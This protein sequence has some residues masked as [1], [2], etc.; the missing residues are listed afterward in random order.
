[1]NILITETL[2]PIAADWLAQRAQVVWCKHDDPGFTDALAQAEG[3]IVRTY[4][5]VND[6][7]L[8]QA[9]KLKVVGR[10][11]VGLDNINVPACRKRNIEVVYTP[12][13]NTQAVVEYV[14]G[15]MLDH[16][17]PRKDLPPSASAA[18]FHQMRKTEVGTQLDQLTLGILGFGRIGKKL[19]RVAHALGM[20]VHAC[21]LLPEAELRKAVNYPFEFVDHDKLYA[22]SDIVTIHID[23]RPRN[24]HLVNREMLAKLKPNVLLINAARG[25]IVDAAALADWARNHP[26]AHAI[27]DVHDPEPPEVKTYPLWDLPNVRLL[28]HLA[29]RTDTAL[30][31]M[32][33]VVRDVLDVLEGGTPQFPAEKLE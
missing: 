10:A 25:M 20:S 11:G 14:L 18:H 27:L 15:L 7:L 32:S 19:G 4:T 9:P 1:M 12:D 23:G 21:D 33:W 13:A 22:T 16:F 31:N 30:L 17:R 26:Q 2:D 8:D 28:P 24:R 3:L 5:Q 6:A 29:S